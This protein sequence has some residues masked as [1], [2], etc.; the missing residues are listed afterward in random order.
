[1]S[2]FLA[3]SAGKFVDARNRAITNAMT[4]FLTVVA[5]YLSSVKNLDSI[6]WARFA[7]VSKLVTVVAF[8][9]TT[10][11]CVRGFK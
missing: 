8:G 3:V 10:L 11:D 7:G 2:T 4:N 6:C 5:L 1:M 9:D